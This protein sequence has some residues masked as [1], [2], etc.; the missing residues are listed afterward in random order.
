MDVPEGSR[1]L[2]QRPEIRPEVHPND[3]LLIA[4]LLYLGFFVQ[5]YLYSTGPLS[6][7]S[8]LMS[9]L[10]KKRSII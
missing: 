3:P 7:L 4:V 1:L 2:V 10:L 9:N 8:Y 5:L 6:T